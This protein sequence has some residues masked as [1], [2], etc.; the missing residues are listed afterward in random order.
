MYEKI[1]NSN[2][3]KSPLGSDI[4]CL[5]ALNTMSRVLKDVTGML[6]AN[7]KAWY[8]NGACEQITVKD[9]GFEIVITKGEKHVVFKLT[10]R[11]YTSHS[12]TL[13]TDKKEVKKLGIY[14]EEESDTPGVV[15]REVTMFFF[16]RVKKN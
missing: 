12:F 4:E 10:G 6:L 13:F 11:T 3:L 5:Y 8:G 7:M 15:W 2:I 9:N 14:D 1:E 16:P